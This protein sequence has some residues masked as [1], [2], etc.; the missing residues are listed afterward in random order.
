M[1]RSNSSL[2]G[3]FDPTLASGFTDFLLVHATVKASS[4][5]RSTTIEFRLIEDLK[6]FSPRRHRDTDL[7]LIFLLV[8]VPPCWIQPR[9]AA[10]SRSE[11]LPAAPRHSPSHRPCQTPRCL[12]P[13][14]PPRRAPPP[15]PCP[16]QPR[17]L[18]R[19]GTGIR[20]LPESPPTSSFYAASWGE[21]S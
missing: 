8:S 9:P 13:E 15:P 1:A 17:H 14:S 19:C 5:A 16:S 3:C 2:S 21:T 11:P 20:A 4:N 12:P 10:N 18:L 7:F 6:T